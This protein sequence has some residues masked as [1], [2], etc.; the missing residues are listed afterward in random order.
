VAP[1]PINAPAINPPAVPQAAKVAGAVPLAEFR[2]YDNV[3]NKAHFTVRETA[4]FYEDDGYVTPNV[5]IEARAVLQDS[6]HTLALSAEIDVRG[7]SRTQAGKSNLRGTAYTGAVV[8][9]TVIGDFS[10]QIHV[11]A[12]GLSSGA[13]TGGFT[14]TSP[15][16]TTVAQGG[17][18]RGIRHRVAGNMA[19][20][21]VGEKTPQKLAKVREAIDTAAGD[22]VA[23]VNANIREHIADLSGLVPQAGQLPVDLQFATRAARPGQRGYLTA[24]LT[25]DSRNGVAERPPLKNPDQA[26]SALYLHEDAFTKAVAPLLAGKTIKF[27]EALKTICGTRYSKQMDF[28]QLPFDPKLEGISM[29]FDKTT[30]FKVSF[31]DNQIKLELNA[32]HDDE[33]LKTGIT[34]DFVAS[35]YH[36]EIVYDVKPEGLVRKSVRAN[37]DQTALESTK[38]ASSKPATHGDDTSLF[39][40]AL[41][42]AVR[43]F[44][45]LEEKSKITEAYSMAFKQK[46]DFP[47]VRVPVAASLVN[48]KSGATP[49]PTQFIQFEINDVQTGNGWFGLSS[50]IR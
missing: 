28:C 32:T 21:S 31:R 49:T 20:A 26:A 47:K 22:A 34:K 29:K 7:S 12:N 44:G 39:G 3:I 35:P 8:D 18:L 30:P 40:K 17:L 6:A 10:K 1:A 16:I 41:N 9:S 43:N 48:P 50:R 15:N 38:S 45:P 5:T 13:L 11:T 27:S 33:K 46:V 42:F 24:A 19:R 2:L 23:N 14:P 4:P 25:G 36:V 37:A